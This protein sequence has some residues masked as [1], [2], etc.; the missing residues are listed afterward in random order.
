MKILKE[1]FSE[2]F[3][4]KLSVAALIV[5]PLLIGFFSIFYV[6]SF[7][8]PF[9][10]MENLKVAI[11]NEDTGVVF[12]EIEKNYGAALTESIM[13]NDSVTWVLEDEAVVESGLENSDYYMALIIPANF[14]AQISAGVSGN[15]QTADLVFWRNARKN[16]LFAQMSSRIE[17]QLAE[18]VNQKVSAQYVQVLEDGIATVA[19]GMQEASDGSSALAEGSASL[20]D[21]LHQAVSGAHV[22]DDGATYLADG[23]TLLASG[24]HSLSG[25]TG[26]LASG[27]DEVAS[28]SAALSSGTGM[29]A[30]GMQTLQGGS[31]QL[32]E[33]TRALNLGIDTAARNMTTVASAIQVLNTTSNTVTTGLTELSPDL[34]AEASDLS[35]LS[36]AL[37]GA[38]DLIGDADTPGTLRY[39]TASA[40]TYIASARQAWSGGGSYK[41][42]TVGE[43]LSLAAGVMESVDTGLQTTKTT[44]DAAVEETAHTSSDLSDAVALIGKTDTPGHTLAYTSSQVTAGL[45]T[46]YTTFIDLQT[47]VTGLRDGSK[48]LATTMQDFADGIAQAS[49]STQAIATGATTVATGASTVSSGAVALQS[50]AEALDEGAQALADGTSQLSSSLPLL[51]SGLT[52][53][54]DGAQSI[55]DGAIML[56]TGLAD[57]VHDI[58]D[59]L[60][61]DTEAFAEYVAQPVNVSEETYG[62]LE[63]F[64]QGFIPFFMTMALWLGSLMIFFVASPFPESGLS[65]SRFHVVLGRFPLYMLFGIIE[66]IAVFLAGLSL[67]I[68]ML[69]ELMLLVVLI[70]TSMVFIAIMQNLN[71]LFGLFGKVLIIFLMI[72]QLAGASG[73]LPVELSSSF[74]IGI[75]QWLPFR[76]SIDA[77]REIMS[78]KNMAT[79]WTDMGTL[80]LFGLGALV[81][82]LFLYPLGK[83]IEERAR[84][85]EIEKVAGYTATAP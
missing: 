11:V 64:G 37:D 56:S 35:A 25:Y 30:Q 44:L 65:V 83:K 60:P 28:G 80:V 4:N 42:K 50:G 21:G 26:S 13:Q 45:G 10:K 75:T 49:D 46:L 34:A 3:R 20:S 9:E 32:V 40:Q 7:Y 8:D 61:A 81:L 77:I 52:S 36:G 79:V 72:I 47:G 48:L 14:S 39:A 18:M 71:L 33:K 82:T 57:G 22:V 63:H 51:V 84:Q 29:L 76:Y 69:N 27:A 31:T 12:D 59:N 24:T 16:Y 5:I 62:D 15:V 78:G 1:S 58:N 73:T 55:S 74:L 2:L 41:G 67:G 23:S 43:W 19:Q 38:D 17:I 54:S 85:K 66:V 68:P 53:A 70:I 6:S